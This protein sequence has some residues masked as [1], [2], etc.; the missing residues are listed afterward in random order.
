[1][2]MALRPSIGNRKMSTM[3]KI[4]PTLMIALMIIPMSIIGQD[5]PPTPPTPVEEVEVP[6]IPETPEAPQ[7]IQRIELDKGPNG[8]E[9]KVETLDSI[10]GNVKDTTKIKMRHST[11]YIV[12]EENDKDSLD[13]DFDDDQNIRAELTH[14]AGIDI[15]MNGF[16][17]ADGNVGL[18]D[19]LDYLEVDLANSR[20]FAINFWEKK[21]PIAS[22]YF[23]ITTGM[24]IEWNNYRLKNDYTLVTSKDTLTAF[25]DTTI[26][27]RKNKLRTAYLNVPIL[28]EFNTSKD[29][30]KSFH[31]AA[32]FV[33]GLHLGTM[34]KQ[35]FEFNDVKMKNKT[36]N[37]MNIETFKVDGM[38]RVGYGKLNLFASTTL[39]QL[40]DEGTGPEVH[41]FRAGITLI[42]FN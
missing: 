36:Q 15:G 25:L 1:M 4:L 39:T 38:I 7:E 22:E 11:I 12:T 23:G 31:L 6:E 20:S 30:E 32:G 9:I 16:T 14:W 5:D 28:L 34:Y 21:I 35:R 40:F 29:P 41:P 37:F 27:V 33:G 26:N 2:N 13:L 42:G 24:G 18:S 19:E 17:G 3:K 10:S 8:F